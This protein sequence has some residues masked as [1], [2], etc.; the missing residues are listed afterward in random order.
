MHD[1]SMEAVLRG[2]S[3]GFVPTMGYLHE[4]HL[5]L[6]RRAKQE[7]DIVVVSSFVSSTLLSWSS[8][9]MGISLK[10]PGKITVTVLRS[11]EIGVAVLKH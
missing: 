1:T 8:P 5:S 4:G 2:K 9:E 11:A 3:T 6:I 7:N 10:A